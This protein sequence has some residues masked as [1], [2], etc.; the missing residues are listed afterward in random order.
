M[1]TKAVKPVLIAKPQQNN[2]FGDVV[3]ASQGGLS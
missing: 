1:E 2:F 3:Q